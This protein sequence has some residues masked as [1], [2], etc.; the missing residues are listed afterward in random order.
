MANMKVEGLQE[1]M[2]G[3]TAIG[4]HAGGIAKKCAFDGARVVA[5]GIAEKVCELPIDSNGGFTKGT[6]PLNVITARDRTDLAACLGVSKIE[7]DG[8]S[9]SVSISFNGYISRTERKYPNGVPAA[10]IARSIEKGT[11]VRAKKPFLRPAIKSNQ[12]A[13]LAAMQKTMDESVAQIQKME[14]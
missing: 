7:N 1:F 12:Q 11:S 5:D 14:G 8:M 6:D 4:E 10:L 13:A 3:L 2:D 9:T